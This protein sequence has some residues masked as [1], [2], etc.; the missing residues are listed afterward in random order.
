MRRH[1]SP[2]THP[3]LSAGDTGKTYTSL[4]T[5]S[6]PTRTSAATPHVSPTKEA[7]LRYVGTCTRS[8]AAGVRAACCALVPRSCSL[9]LHQLLLEQDTHLFIDAVALVRMQRVL[10]TKRRTGECL[11][12]TFSQVSSKQR[13]RGPQRS[14]MFLRSAQASVSAEL[15]RWADMRNRPRAHEGARWP[16]DRPTLNAPPSASHVAAPPFAS[17]GAPLERV[18]PATHLE[19]RA[20]GLRPKVRCD[21]KCFV[22]MQRRSRL[23]P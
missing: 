13:R 3:P 17:T 18:G 16:S 19:A 5:T 20:W 2:L 15:L 7:V 4:K 9:T 10:P 14:S 8:V 12:E 23:W 11:S 21:A 6:G 1:R 22:A